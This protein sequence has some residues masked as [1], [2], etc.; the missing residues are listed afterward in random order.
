M[1]WSRTAF[2]G[3]DGI[4]PI[5][6]IKQSPDVSHVFDTGQIDSL[7]NHKN[8]PGDYGLDDLDNVYF[9]GVNILNNADFELVE[10]LG[11]TYNDS[12][13]PPSGTDITLLGWKTGGTHNSFNHYT[14]SETDG[15]NRL[16]IIR[17]FG[18]ITTMGLIYQEVLTPSGATYTYQIYVH[19][20]GP[21]FRF[22]SFTGDAEAPFFDIVNFPPSVGDDVT[23]TGTIETGGPYTNFCIMPYDGTIGTSIIDNIVLTPDNKHIPDDEN[24]TEE[25]S[26]GD[27][28]EN[29][30]TGWFR[31]DGSTT[32]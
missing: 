16:N 28:A 9:N 11:Y 29:S 13:V 27:F 5:S 3:K 22:L 1:A 19:T 26:F 23:L 21:G 8:K 6:P 7:V 18:G 31:D 15:S 30:I 14:I 32:T 24:D 2:K 25:S 4:D 10:L 12:A 20:I 17:G